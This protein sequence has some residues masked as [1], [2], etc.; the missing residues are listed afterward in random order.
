VSVNDNMR[1]DDPDHD[2][3]LARLYQAA[4]GEE[5]PA[6]LDAAILAAARREVGARP[7]VIGAG[8]GQT[9]IPP[10][11]AKRNWYMPVSI[12][13]VL[14][15]SVSLVVQVHQEK[16][17]ELAQP[18]AATSPLPKAQAPA[19]A[20]AAEPPA[21]SSE[22]PDAVL[23]D[24]A[25][26][27]A[28]VAEEKQPESAKTTGAAT[29]PEA[30]GELAKKQRAEKAESATDS[31]AAMTGA[32]RK[33][34]STGSAAREQGPAGETAP[35]LKTAPGTAFGGFASGTQPSA[36]ARRPEPF[37]EASERESPVVSA[38][39]PAPAQA[40]RDAAIEARA[41]N[42]ADRSVA[43]GALQSAPVAPPAAVAAAPRRVAPTEEALAQPAPAMA[44]GRTSAAPPPP[45]PAKGAPAAKR[46]LLWR[47]LEDQPPEKWLERL[48]EFRRDNRQADANELLAEF[49]RRF[50]DH[51]A[52]AR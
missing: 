43:R 48:A 52:S 23:R 47:G 45:P 37:P 9:S 3:R 1:D 6:A 33:D 28:K 35:A 32:Q 17:D 15:L 31:A 50:P 24:A 12:V 27:K 51:P 20:P 21:A 49:R 13:A 10:V 16:G 11:R 25:P 39:A 44:E 19:A 18:P 22:K 46:A 14:V 30:Y 5:P 40:S 26:A 29:A 38:P 34:Q 36:V 41:R 4:S 42:E 2:P 8:G 7:Q